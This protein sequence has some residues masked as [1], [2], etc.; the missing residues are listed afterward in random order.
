M[1]KILGLIRQEARSFAGPLPFT[2]EYEQETH[3]II[4]IEARRTRW[5]PEPV[6]VRVDRVSFFDR[7]P[8]KG[9]PPVLAAAFRVADI[10]YQWQRGQRYPLTPEAA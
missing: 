2:F 5:R 4:A 8:F 9:A 10:D 1:E 6:D 7:P 3:A